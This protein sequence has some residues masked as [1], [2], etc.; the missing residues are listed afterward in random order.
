MAS[1]TV[2]SQS[3]QILPVGYLKEI[4]YWNAVRSSAFDQNG[5]DSTTS[6][7]N[8]FNVSGIIF[9]TEFCYALR[10]QTEISQVLLIFY[11]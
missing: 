4:V 11:I 2:R 7:W 1:V 9:I 5:C 6:V 3:R 8:L 10:K